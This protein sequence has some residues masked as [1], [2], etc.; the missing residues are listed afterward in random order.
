MPDMMRRGAWAAMAVLAFLCAAT[1]GGCS[2]GEEKPAVSGKAEVTA[3]AKVKLPGDPEAGKQIYGKY[4]HYCHGIE[5]RGDGPVSIGISPH[6]ADFTADAKRMA[7]TDQELMK[8][9]TEGIKRDIGG[10]AMFMPSWKAILTEQERWDA[11][12]YVRLLEKRGK[13]KNAAA[14][15]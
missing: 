1:L 15:R 6:P 7:K 13:E 11:L 5:G 12:A 8:S 3:Q 10:E 2:G 14:R 9:I 4:C